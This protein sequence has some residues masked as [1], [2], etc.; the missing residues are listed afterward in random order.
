MADL[1]ASVQA[2]LHAFKAAID[3]ANGHV[4]EVD[5]LMT[6][7]DHEFD[8]FAA[9][10][11]SETAQHLT[12]LHGLTAQCHALDGE[13]THA[14]GDLSHAVSAAEQDLGQE[15]DT[16]EKEATNLQ[17]ENDGFV[18]KTEEADHSVEQIV[19]EAGHFADDTNAKV[20]DA[21]QHIIDTGHQTAEKFGNEL[22]H[23]VNDLHQKI[24]QT[25]HG[26]EQDANNHLHTLEQDVHGYA[27]HVSEQAQHFA[28]QAHN[29]GNAA[30]DKLMAT[31]HDLE[32]GVTG[33][34]GDLA[35]D[36]QGF[37]DSFMKLS[38]FITTLTSE[39]VDAVS[40]LGQAMDAANVGLN[41]VVKT[42][43]NVKDILD[44]IH[45]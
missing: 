7:L 18:Q 3:L 44:E 21:A 13:L 15:V 34:L 31:V 17:H 33:H 27:S 24:D 29:A 35:H 14:F 11:Q 16:L 32:H 1:H 43:T 41:G 28:D 5:A 40:E 8:S 6:T 26:F 23:H 4:M 22:V 12:L 42:V 45:L 36:I 10:V 39:G 19:Q 37:H 2:Q 38:E 9:H 20:H 30:K 25:Y